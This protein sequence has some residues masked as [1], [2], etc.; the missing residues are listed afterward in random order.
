MTSTSNPKCILR[1]RRWRFSRRGIALV[2]VLG[3]LAI[4]LGFSYA[5]LRS[6]TTD[7]EL[8]RNQSRKM[9]A[10]AAAQAGIAVALRKLYDGTWAGADTSFAGDL[11]ADKL[12]GFTVSYTTGDSELTS[13]SADWKEYPFRITLLSKGYS[14][15]PSTAASRSE[16][17][18]R[19]VVQLVRR[20]L[21]TNLASTPGLETLSICQTGNDTV[22]IQYPI[23]L[24]DNVYIQ[25]EIEFSRQYPQKHKDTTYMTFFDDI[26]DM[27]HDVGWDYRPF[28]GRLFTPSSRQSGGGDV[29]KVLDAQLHVPR[30]DVPVSS[31]SLVP[32]ISTFSGYR[33]YDKGKQYAGQALTVTPDSADLIPNAE[34]VVSGGSF[35]PDPQANPLGI[36]T[37]TQGS[38]GFSSNTSFQGMLVAYG[39]GGSSDVHIAGTNVAIQAPT[40][41]ALAGDATNYQLPA[42]VADDD[43]RIYDG[44]NR[45]INGWIVCADEFELNSGAST[46]AIAVTGGVFCR[47]L[48]LEGRSSWVQSQSNW[49]SAYSAWNGALLKLGQNWYF[50]GWLD[51]NRSSWGIYLT[52]RL[53]FSATPSGV[54]NHVPDLSQPIYVPHSEDGGLRWDVLKW[55]EVGAS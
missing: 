52:P 36:F 45:T 40:L 38:V 33:L 49:Q 34:Y 12:Q 41:P 51:N 30:T 11:T 22:E 24:N 55:Q 15:D 28:S 13:A 17:S 8:E 27:Y 48:Y 23:R 53:I 29:V 5:L 50:P 9:D 10:R 21:N 39:S 2:L 20:K 6:H 46:T 42:V 44:T 54:T 4:T 25:G 1:P 16:Y 32:T 31:A 47:K 43:V 18:I 26:Y 37:S 7:H 14:I 19:V 35:A 3:L